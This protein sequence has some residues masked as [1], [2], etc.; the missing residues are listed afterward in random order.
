[1]I[2]YEILTTAATTKADT[3]EEKI[4]IINEQFSILDKLGFD[5]STVYLAHYFKSEFT[6]EEIT[7][8]YLESLKERLAVKDGIELVRFENG[9]IGFMAS[10]SGIENG[11]EIIGK[12]EEGGESE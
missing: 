2:K 5:D 8:G 11:F 7:N 9:N 10:Y 4:M 1:M 12:Y 6:E 3:D